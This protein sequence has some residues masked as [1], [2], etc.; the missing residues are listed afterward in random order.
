MRRLIIICEG[1]TERE[2]CLSILAPYF[3]HS[4]I[5]IQ[6][7]LIQKSMGGIVKWQE[8][9]KQVIN[10]L[11]QDPSVYVSLFIDYYGLYA[12]YL[13]PKWDECEATVDRSKRM[14]ILEQGM[15]EDIPDAIRY[16]FIPYIQLH[17]FEGLLF[18][19]YKYFTQQFEITEL[20]HRLE[21][22][23]VFEDHP[24]PE[25]INNGKETAPSKRLMK[26]IQGY[27]KPIYGNIL[28]ECIGVEN[29]RAKCPRFNTWLQNIEDIPVQQQDN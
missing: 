14:T 17:E 11:N 12:K 15:E 27:N 26:Y 20:N 16:R 5:S 18:I 8:I 22:Q 4:G 24:N 23:K 29:I 9:R 28:A 10:T 2:F 25:L 19:D 21:F 1:P 13:F 6:A 3:I 7:T